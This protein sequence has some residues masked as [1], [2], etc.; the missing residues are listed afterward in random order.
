[1]LALTAR[2]EALNYLGGG[3]RG[4]QRSHRC[5][6]LAL[7]PLCQWRTSEQHVM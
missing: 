3:A 5:L 2:R 4:G 7:S 1:M 6:S